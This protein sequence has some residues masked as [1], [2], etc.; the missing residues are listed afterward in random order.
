MR[1]KVSRARAVSVRARADPELELERKELERRELERRELEREVDLTQ[2]EWTP[3]RKL[4]YV[5]LN[6][7]LIDA[8]A[9][10][11]AER[12]IEDALAWTKKNVFGNSDA[13]YKLYQPFAYSEDAL[14]ERLLAIYLV[15][16]LRTFL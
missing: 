8:S 5:L 6:P 4:F 11:D 7:E 13:K 1:R 16:Q 12:Y 2:T 3:T 14:D 10:A 15:R 9:L